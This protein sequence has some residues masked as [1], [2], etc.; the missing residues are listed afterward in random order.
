M[1]GQCGKGQ[2]TPILW[3]KMCR[4]LKEGYVSN[5]LQQ[6]NEDIE[7]EACLKKCSAYW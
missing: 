2:N 7:D 5:I 6:V 4:R 3:H 1:F